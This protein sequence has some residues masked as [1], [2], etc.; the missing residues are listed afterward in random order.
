[1]S[2]R[3]VLRRSKVTEP[4][5]ESDPEIPCTIP[6]RPARSSIA[7]CIAWSR[8]LKQPGQPDLAAFR[9]TPGRG[10]RQQGHAQ[11]VR[12]AGGHAGGSGQVHTHP[13]HHHAPSGTDGPSAGGLQSLPGHRAIPREGARTVS[14]RR[15]EPQVVRDSGAMR[16]AIHCFRMVQAMNLRKTRK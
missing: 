2:L 9:R 8:E 5:T 16:P 15:G 14:V 3:S 11:L 1:M 12:L 13:L 7:F 4:S 6:R 10:Y